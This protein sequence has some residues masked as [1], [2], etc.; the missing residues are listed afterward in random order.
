MN[1]IFFKKIIPSDF[2]TKLLILN[3]LLS[4]IYLLDYSITEIKQEIILKAPIVLYS[5]D[6]GSKKQK[7]KQIIIPNQLDKKLI[8]T[9]Q[10][11][12]QIL[13]EPY[14]KTRFHNN[15]KIHILLIRKSKKYN[16]IAG[17]ITHIYA[18]N[19]LLFENDKVDEVLLYNKTDT[20]FNKVVILIIYIYTIILTLSLFK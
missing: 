13:C 4:S 17:V 19:R 20:I 18:G 12:P 14:Q 11:M 10:G 2:G 9:C 5:A 3:C 7:T 8:I 1:H 6:T 15:E 16:Y